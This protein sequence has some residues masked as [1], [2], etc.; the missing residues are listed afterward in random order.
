M[1][2][3][4]WLWFVVSHWPDG[5][6]CGRLL[7]G[8]FVRTGCDAAEAPAQV[9]CAGG[10]LPGHLSVVS[11]QCGSVRAAELSCVAWPRLFMR[12]HMPVVCSQTH[13][14]WGALHLLHLLPRAAQAP[15]VAPSTV[16]IVVRC[17]LCVCVCACVSSSKLIVEH[18]LQRHC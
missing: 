2:Q 13:P 9:W 7:S 3:A 10:H 15:E 14:L 18:E 1:C 4:W 8:A 17:V 5:T 11:A 6:A 16:R 12:P